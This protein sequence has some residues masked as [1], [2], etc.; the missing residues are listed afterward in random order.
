M[1]LLKRCRNVHQ[2]SMVSTDGGQGDPLDVILLLGILLCLDGLVLLHSFEESVVVSC[3][4]PH[5][6]HQRQKT[7]HDNRIHKNFVMSDKIR[8]RQA[9]STCV[10]RQ[11]SS[12]NPDGVCAHPIQEILR[13]VTVSLSPALPAVQSVP[14]VQQRLELL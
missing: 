3:I 7:L 11:L 13:E 6:S 1:A 4:V 5:A 14:V 2:A 10:V 8:N 12:G 9:G